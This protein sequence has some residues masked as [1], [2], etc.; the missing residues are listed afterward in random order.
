M[1]AGVVPIL[2]GRGVRLFDGI[3]PVD[4]EMAD[5]SRSGQVANLRFR[6]VK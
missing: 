1:R 3:H 2:L 6:V 4:L 5:V